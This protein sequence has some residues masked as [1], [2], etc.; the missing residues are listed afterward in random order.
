MFSSYFKLGLEHILDPNG[1]DHVLFILVLTIPFLLKDWKKVVL[2]ATAFTLGH[3]LTLALAALDIVNV[4]SQWVEISIAI[5]ILLTA[6]LNILQNEN[7]TNKMR[8]STAA[9]FGLIHGLGFSNFFKTILGKDELILPLFAF[10]IGVEAAQIIIV[11][12]TL[13]LGYILVEKG[14]LKQ[15]YWVN[16][17]SVFVAVWAI[18]L[19]VERI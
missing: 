19:I 5:T 8:Y 4:N 12:A 7:L 16:G 14:K 3:S 1:L 11:L 6:L 2:L 15:K 17:I 10:N 9:I 18:K 13:I